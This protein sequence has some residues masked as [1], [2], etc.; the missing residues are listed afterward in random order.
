MTDIDETGVDDA[1]VDVG[2]DVS[3]AP[4]ESGRDEGPRWDSGAEYAQKYKDP[5]T[6]WKSYRELETRFSQTRPSE[7]EPEP[8]QYE[9]PTDFLGPHLDESTIARLVAATERDPRMAYEN[10]AK[11]VEYWGQ[12]AVDYAWRSWWNKSPLEAN[13][14][15]LQTKLSE[16][17]ERARSELRAE[18]APFLNHTYQGISQTAIERVTQSHPLLAQEDYAQKIIGWLQENPNDPLNA[19][20]R[21][22]LDPTAAS[23]RIVEIG[24]NIYMRENPDKIKALFQLPTPE[25]EPEVDESGK[26]QPDPRSKTKTTNRNTA[27]ASAD[28]DDQWRAR[29]RAELGLPQK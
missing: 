23:Q 8:E 5:D 4:A 16:E 2:T 7:P 26:K 14:Y 12:D 24:L 11:N 20:P 9:D 13:E 21:V 6:L 18:M 28:A 27:R 1:A 17:R 29:L 19:D 22:N 15:Y 3:D 25:P 10:L